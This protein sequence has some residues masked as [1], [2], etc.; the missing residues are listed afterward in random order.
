MRRCRCSTPVPVEHADGHHAFCEKCGE[1]VPDPRDRILATL[2]RR[3]AEHERKI[4]RLEA[5]LAER[6]GKGSHR[7]SQRKR[8]RVIADA[9]RQAPEQ[10]NRRLAKRLGVSHPTVAAVRREL[11]EVESGAESLS[12]KGA[13]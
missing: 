6:N 8:R 9:I 1:R 3:L 2:V 7:L 4:A 10:S 5:Q 11:A 13:R 12:T